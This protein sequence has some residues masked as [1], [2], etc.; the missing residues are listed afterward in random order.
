MSLVPRE[1][2]FIS[3]L[4]MSLRAGIPLISEEEANRF[5]REVPL[6]RSE[7]NQ[8]FKEAYRLAQEG[9]NLL[10]LF[11]TALLFANAQTQSVFPLWLPGRERI[12]SD[13]P[14]RI[15]HARETVHHAYDLAINIAAALNNKRLTAMA[16]SNYANDIRFF[17]ETTRAREHATYAL[18]LAR[19]L[20]D[21]IQVA[22][23]EMLLERLKSNPDGST[24]S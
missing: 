1:V 21:K 8:R 4:L 16:F 24:E 22:K 3:S 17:G 6:I 13:I 7:I 12:T 18:Q 15:K 14:Q 23:S 5:D 19:E 2:E 11:T 10:A 9:R 20:G